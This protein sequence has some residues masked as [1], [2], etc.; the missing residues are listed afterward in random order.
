MFLCLSASCCIKNNSSPLLA[1]A[2]SPGN[3]ITPFSVPCLRFIR[4]VGISVFNLSARNNKA[5]FLFGTDNIA[6]VRAHF[7]H[8]H[9]SAARA[10]FACRQIPRYVI[11]LRIILAAVKRS[12]FFALAL[13]Y[14]PAAFGAFHADFFNNGLCVFALRIIRT[15]KEPSESACFIYH[16]CAAFIAGDIRN[17]IGNFNTLNGLECLFKRFFKRRIEIFNQILPA[18]PCLLPL[19]PIVTPYPP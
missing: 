19:S 17:L 13:D 5:A 8:G 6:S 15:G 4:K 14:F 10:R 16:H 11:T 3:E 1:L 2:K 12:A 18:F 9:P 7:P